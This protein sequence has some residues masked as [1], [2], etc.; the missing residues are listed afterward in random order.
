[1]D[2]QVSVTKLVTAQSNYEGPNIPLGLVTQVCFIQVWCFSLPDDFKCQLVT[3]IDVHRTEK[4]YNIQ[5][6]GGYKL[7]Q[8]L[9]SFCSHVV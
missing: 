8:N 2:G 6:S 7:T 5:Q 1:M 3:K 9:L 4:R